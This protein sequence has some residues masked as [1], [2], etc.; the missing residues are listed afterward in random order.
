MK[1]NWVFMERAVGT[2]RV[3]GR[4][5]VLLGGLEALCA[6]PLS[7]FLPFS[8]AALLLAVGLI[9][10]LN[11]SVFAT[12]GNRKWLLFLQVFN[13]VAFALILELVLWSGQSSLHLPGITIALL[14]LGLFVF[15]FFRL[16][17]GLMRKCLAAQ[18]GVLASVL[19]S[20]ML[21][22]ELRPQLD[23]GQLFSF[24]HLAMALRSLFLGPLSLLVVV[25]ISGFIKWDRYMI[26]LTGIC[27]GQWAIGCLELGAE[28]A[29]PSLTLVAFLLATGFLLLLL[30]SLIP[31]KVNTI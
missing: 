29:M 2:G 11:A 9:V 8:R 30:A 28:L 3:G 15:G 20:W 24:G 13:L 26:L 1:T 21:V 12:V 4:V 14:C 27:L 18:Q 23:P 31:R 10:A 25:F 6:L 17:K 16:P 7:Y 19:V 5:F 22:Q